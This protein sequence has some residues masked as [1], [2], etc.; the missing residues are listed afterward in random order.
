[1]ESKSVIAT[2][3]ERN[4]NAYSRKPAV[5][6]QRTHTRATSADGFATTCKENNNSIECDMPTIMGGT[7]RAP[8]PGVLGRACLTSCIVMGLRIAAECRGV[9]VSEIAVDLTMEWDNRGI[10][11]MDGASAGPGGIQLQI[12]LTSSAPESE[13]RKVVDEGLKNDPWLVALQKPHKVDIDTQIKR[14]V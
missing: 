4:Q 12:E 5:A 2:A 9:P 8:T 14:A 11:G 3:L 1:M 6:L 10:F 7:D 13:L